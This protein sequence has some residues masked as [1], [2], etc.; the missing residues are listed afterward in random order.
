VTDIAQAATDHLA[1]Q[2][3]M[4]AYARGVDTRDYETLETLFAENGRLVTRVGSEAEPRYALEGRERVVR[5]MKTVEKYAATTHL[6]G[7]PWIELDGDEARCETHCLAHHLYEREGEARIYLM[8]IRYQDHC[9][10]EGQLWRFVE[11][12]LQVDWEEDRTFH[13]PVA[14]LGTR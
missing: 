7:L 3:L 13:P 8:S 2:G 4:A 11:R 9:A 12:R 14:P 5:A 1:L 10:R 6:L